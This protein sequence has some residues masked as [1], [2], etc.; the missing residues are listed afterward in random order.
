MKIWPIVCV[1]GCSIPAWAA[2]SAKNAEA[3][4]TTNQYAKQVLGESQAMGGKVL[5][6]I[7]VASYT[8]VQ[9]AHGKNQVWLATNKI[10]VKKGDEVSF[11]NA[12]PMH[13]FHSKTLNRTFDE[14]YFVTDLSVKR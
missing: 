2:D 7:D 1:F 9:F 5:D 8:Y 10:D 13:N 11:E 3:F 4:Q 6:K 12:Q 14:I